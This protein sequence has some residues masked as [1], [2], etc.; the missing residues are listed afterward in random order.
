M[1]LLYISFGTRVYVSQQC[2]FLG[3][4]TLLYYVYFYYP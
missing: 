2:N 3:A 4:F 1:I